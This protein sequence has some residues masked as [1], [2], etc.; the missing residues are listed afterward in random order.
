MSQVVV[1]RYGAPFLERELA[2]ELAHAPAD[3]KENGR[4]LNTAIQNDLKNIKLLVD[5]DTK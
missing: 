2:K 4:S 3:W 1:D 5:S